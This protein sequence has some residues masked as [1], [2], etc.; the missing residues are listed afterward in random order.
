MGIPANTIWAC[1]FGADTNGGG[2][3]VGTAGGTDYSF[4]PAA[5]RASA[6]AVANGTTTLTSA[7]G[8]FTPAMVGNLVY[9]AGGSAALAATR[10]YIVAVTDANTIVVDAVVAAGT[11]ITCNVGGALLTLA[12]LN[13]G[14]SRGMIGSNLAWLS[15][16]LT[17]GAALA[18]AQTVAPTNAIMPTRLRGCGAVRGDGGF[19]TIRWN[20]LGATFLSFNG[21]GWEL[22]NL[23]VDV[24]S[25]TA[26]SG[27]GGTGNNVDIYNCVIK[28][29][30]SSGV[31][32]SGAQYWR[33]MG[34]EVFNNTGGGLS[35]YSN[36]QVIGNNVHN[37][38][39]HGIRA[40]SVGNVITHNH[41]WANAA[42]GIITNANGYVADNNVYGN[43]TQTNGIRS[44]VTFPASTVINNIIDSVAGTGFTAASAAGWPASPFV[45][46]NSY[47]G[48]GADMANIGDA[49]A[50]NPINAADLYAFQYNKAPAAD[51]YANKAGTPPDFTPNAAATGGAIIRAAAV[52][53][54]WPALTMTQF[55]DLGPTQHQD[56]GGSGGGGGGGTI[57]YC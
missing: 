40:V 13:Q 39:A 26:S 6:D 42:D 43:N 22:S 37:N 19:A 53:R 7:A 23:I 34:C 18:F 16:T 24:N 1:G 8:G 38:G 46:G 10:R 15:G 41:I 5:Q 44:T 50:V 52:P 4:Q 48:N 25:K 49:G 47:H 32:N 28:N 21:N 30:T 29:A 20:S 12:E 33:I 3:V 9:L 36:S 54:S 45:D 55:A 2:F 14:P 35:V 27:I 51:P 31:N 11:G 57:I 17:V 56:A